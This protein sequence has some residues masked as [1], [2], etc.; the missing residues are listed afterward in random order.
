M[1]IINASNRYFSLKE[2]EERD[3]QWSFPSNPAMLRHTSQPKKLEA[4]PKPAKQ[5]N[6]AGKIRFAGAMQSPVEEKKEAAT[7]KLKGLAS[8]IRFA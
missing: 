1:Q 6:F 3:I 8:K 5:K 2:C 4:K 7:K